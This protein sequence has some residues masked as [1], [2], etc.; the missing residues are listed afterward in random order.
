MLMQNKPC[1]FKIFKKIDIAAF[2]NVLMQNN[3][4]WVNLFTSKQD[5]AG[6]LLVNNKHIVY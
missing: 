1:V 5:T 4:K 3:K 2:C 6:C